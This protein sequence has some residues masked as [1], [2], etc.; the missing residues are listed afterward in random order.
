MCADV[1]TKAGIGLGI[2]CRPDPGPA[3]IDGRRIRRIFG[4]SGVF[5]GCFWTYL[6]AFERARAWLLSGSFNNIRAD[7][8]DPVS[9][10]RRQSGANPSPAK[11]KGPGSHFP[12]RH[13]HAFQ[14]F[15]RGAPPRPP[16]VRARVLN[17]KP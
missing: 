1:V 8:P 14:S 5:W 4:L 12:P 10:I 6:G 11:A 2:K 16:A 7:P 13:G 3:V 17:P 9:R 15:R